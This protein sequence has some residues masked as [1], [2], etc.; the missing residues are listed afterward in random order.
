MG[1]EAFIWQ[2]VVYDAAYKV[3]VEPF[4]R[5][6]G[7]TNLCV[8]VHSDRSYDI[9][10]DEKFLVDI[11]EGDK[12]IV[13]V[14]P[15]EC[16]KFWFSSLEEVLEYSRHTRLFDI[17]PELSELY[18]YKYAD[19]CFTLDRFKI[20]VDCELVETIVRPVKE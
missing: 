20:T 6:S 17:Y 8:M 15:C 9:R 10:C 19:N 4:S 11:K 7:L 1:K 16:T 2:G 14:H 18:I 5:Y 3:E 12:R 13:T